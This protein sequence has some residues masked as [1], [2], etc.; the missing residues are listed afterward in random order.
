MAGK[1]AKTVAR[2]NSGLRSSMLPPQAAPQTVALV[3]A[4]A[5]PHHG[6]KENWQ[7]RERRGGD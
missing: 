5:F 3:I 1:L 7:N 4:A 6:I 2:N